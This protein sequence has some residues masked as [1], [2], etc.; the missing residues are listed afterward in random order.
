LLAMSGMRLIV[1]LAALAFASA[2]A[3]YYDDLP[4]YGATDPNAVMVE[5]RAQASNIGVDSPTQLTSTAGQEVSLDAPDDQYAD[6]DPSALTDFKATLDPYGTW[7]DD[8]TYGTVWQPDASVVGSDFAPYVTGGHWGYED[9]DYVWVSDWDWGWAPFHYGRWVFIRGRGWSWIAGRRYAGAWV[10]WRTGAPGYVGWGPRAPSWYWRNGTAY[11]ITWR[12][13]SPYVFC[14]TGDFFSP[15]VHERILA[16]PQVGV[17]AGRTSVWDGGRTPAHPN[18]GPPLARLGLAA[19]PPLPRSVGI[20]R[21]LAW[22]HPSTAVS[23]GGRAPIQTIARSQPRSPS[24]WQGRG[25][26]EPERPVATAPQYFG[27]R[28]TRIPYYRGPSRSFGGGV[29]RSPAMEYGRAAP[30]YRGAAPAYRG[31]SVYRGGGVT[32]PS[33]SPSHTYH[34]SGGGHFGGGHFGGG[35]FG[36]GGHSGGGGHHR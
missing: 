9:D 21:A 11:D 16:G 19:P 18:V 10:S 15:R 20:A 31:P 29:G 17:I 6:T 25:V 1:P 22:A 36:G 32:M 4:A 30:V 28:P 24:S 12:V 35:H 27:V 26:V 3:P 2:C 34:S 13:G 33:S 23:L 8:P 5:E 7:D 14:G